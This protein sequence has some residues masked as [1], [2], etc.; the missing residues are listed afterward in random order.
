MLVGWMLDEIVF[1]V[2]TT[3]K[4][5]WSTWSRSGA[6]CPVTVVSV[7]NGL[8]VATSNPPPPFLGNNTRFSLIHFWTP[9]ILSSHLD[10]SSH[11]LSLYLTPHLCFNFFNLSV[12]LPDWNK[13]IMYLKAFVWARRIQRNPK[14]VCDMWRFLLRAT[15]RKVWNTPLP[16]CWPF[17]ETKDS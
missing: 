6:T 11:F 17:M 4:M 13:A 9:I 2:H 10:L 7:R 14:N 16:D 15:W 5:F 8:L 12:H 1:F 3:L